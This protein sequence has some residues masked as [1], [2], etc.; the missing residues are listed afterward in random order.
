MVGGDYTLDAVRQS[1]MPTPA[2]QTH[3]AV[4]RFFASGTTPVTPDPVTGGQAAGR[5]GSGPCNI[6]P[7][8]FINPVGLAM[9][10]LY[11]RCQLHQL[12]QHAGNFTN[13]PVRKLN[14]G[15]FDIRLDHNFSSKDSAFARFSYDQATSFV[16]GG[17]PG[18]AEASAFAS[19][20]DITNHG[21]NVADLGNS[22]FFRPNNQ[23]IQCR[24][25]PNLQS[26]PLVRRWLLR[27]RQH[28]H[29]G[30]ELEQQVSQGAPAG[31]V[32]QSSKD[33]MSCGL[34]STLL[35][36]YWALGDRGFAPFQGGTNVFSISDSFDMIRGKHDIKVGG[37][38]RAQQ[39]NVETNA[40]QDGFILKFGGYTGDAS[41]DLL[42]GQMGGA[43]HDQTFFGATTGRRWKLFRPFVQDDWRVTSNLTLNLGLAWAF[44]TPITEDQNRQ[45]NF[46][47]AT[48]Q[49]LV[50]GSAPTTGLHDLRALGWKR[51]H[52][53]G[54]DRLRTAHRNC[55]EAVRKPEHGNP[56]GV[57][58]L[59]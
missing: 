13:V 46:D 55:L 59:P 21:R 14:E 35:T 56:P 17:S 47:F 19:T 20:Q 29:S 48:G 42:L 36:D 50:A 57:C 22:R 30:R 10:Q 34:T 43:I 41:A 12:G 37:G 11:P 4:P 23:S 54:Q 24:L 58:H 33:C 28:R 16:P 32:S 5:C 39:M 25:Q 38:I 44:V 3:T 51:R 27:S 8:Q 26:H 9:M 2:A 45:A 1:R 52:R 31:V 40:F 15:E 18:F 7:Q 49:L 53:I 6:I